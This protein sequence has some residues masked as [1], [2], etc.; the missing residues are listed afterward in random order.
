IS[1][2]FGTSLF[3]L[4]VPEMPTA[5][6]L[7][8]RDGLRL[9]SAAASLVGV[10]ESFIARYPVEAQVVLANLVD[11]SDLL[12]LL[13]NG[14]HSAKAGYL[15]GAFRKTGRPELADDIISAM[16][17]AGYDVRERNPF[18]GGQIF[19]TTHRAAAPIVARLEM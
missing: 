2:L 17:S 1:L 7:V 5:A 14:G 8:T 16:K 19:G 18:E 11:A 10:A 13:L 3:D 4:K 12:R 6:S 15:A 9:F